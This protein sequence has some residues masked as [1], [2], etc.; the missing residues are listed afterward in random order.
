[1]AMSLARLLLGLLLGSASLTAAENPVSLVLTYRARPEQRVAFREW[2]EREGAAQFAAWKREG[3]FADCLVLFTSFAATT[4]VDAVVVLDFAHFS[5]SARW[6]E[7]ER[8]RPG[9]LDAEA[10]RLAS[11]ESCFHAVTLARAGTPRRGAGSAYLLAIYDVAASA[12]R[13]R[14]YVAGYITPQMEGWRE[15]QA[16]HSYR[17]FFNH[18]PLSVVW[19]AI[20]LLEYD[21]VAALGRRDEVKA[22]VRARLAGTDATWL[23][24]SK[25]KSGIR[26]EKALVVAQAIPLPP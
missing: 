4:S 16:L 2:L 26:T 18:A 8:S 7:I 25:E 13:Y 12:D 21:D 9:G 11:V 6:M 15:A 20:L 10:L 3:V 5:D 23:A 22:A 17:L 19:D 24:W 14:S 1:M